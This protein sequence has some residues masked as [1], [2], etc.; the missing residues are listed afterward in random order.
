M[1]WLALTAALG[2][3][4]ALG[5]ALGVAVGRRHAVHAPPRL[6][7]YRHRQTGV[8]LRRRLFGGE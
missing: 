7:F 8:E 2:L 3:A 6:A 1:P 4:F 5:V